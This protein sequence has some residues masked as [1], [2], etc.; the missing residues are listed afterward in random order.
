LIL[1]DC[2]TEPVTDNGA[3]KL[4]FSIL[5][6]VAEF[7]KSRIAD[8]MR[9][10]RQGKAARGGHIGGQAPYGYRVEGKGRGATLVPVEAEKA[11]VQA[12]RELRAQ[13]FS[14]AV[15]AARS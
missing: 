7:E 4:F 14:Y 12:V 5:A 11:I 1:V 8:R 10:G 6:S 15:I 9:E 2:S 3:G 13:R